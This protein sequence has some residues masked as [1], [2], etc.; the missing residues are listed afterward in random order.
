MLSLFF[1]R[2]LTAPGNS[3]NLKFKVSRPGKSCKV[4]KINQMIA[5]FMTDVHVSSLYIHYL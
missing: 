3:W 2:I 5:A 1:D 4:I